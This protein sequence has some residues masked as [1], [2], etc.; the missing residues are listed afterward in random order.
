MTLAAT[1]R[2]LGLDFAAYLR[3]RF[4]TANQIPPLPDL[5]TARASQFALA[6]S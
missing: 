5:I 3:D 4:T 2:K 6:P 1:T